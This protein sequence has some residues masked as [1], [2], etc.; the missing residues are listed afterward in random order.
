MSQ[1]IATPRAGGGD[2]RAIALVSSGHFL[3]HFYVLA[4][5]PLFPLLKGELGVSYAALGAAITAYN[6]ASGLAQTP[7][8]FLV[9]RV[10][11]ARVLAVGLALEAAAIAALGLSASYAALLALLFVAGLGSSV[12]HP[13]D[14][15]ILSGRVDRRRLGRAFSLH[16]FSGYLGFAVAPGAMVALA[17]VTDWRAGLVIA[18]GVGLALALAVFA[19]RR[20]L[21]AHE[22]PA[23][24]A[25]EDA[26]VQPAAPARRLVL[27]GGPVLLFFLFY[28]ASAMGSNG[29]QTFSVA[30]LTALYDAPLAAASATLTAFLVGNAIGILAGGLA[31]DRT[32]RHGALAVGGTVLAA[33]FVGAVA[34]FRLPLWAVTGALALAGLCQ[35]LTRPSRDMMVRAITPPGATGKV[36]GFVST[37]L[38]LGGALAPVMF[39]FAV[40][41]GAP[42]LVFAL[43][44]AFLLAAAAFA[45]AGR[46]SRL[47]ATADQPPGGGHD[48]GG[49]RELE[50]V[51]QDERREPDRDRLVVADQ[52]AEDREPGAVDREVAEQHGEGG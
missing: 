2:G 23:E 45:A 17:A 35:G 13:A 29:I 24:A 51:A 39:G 26:P 38:N 6:V 27:L 43:A 7:A 8:G 40:D 5:P 36:F 4:L 37:G 19:N 15:A 31:A 16:T 11:A 20:A 49:K 44:V 21:D 32:R 14:Y 3:T 1:A 25:A 33:A 48:A 46:L 12:V 34:V 47:P 52:R 28:V 50:R 41:R 9:D 10:G 18:G 30:A 42:A 22:A